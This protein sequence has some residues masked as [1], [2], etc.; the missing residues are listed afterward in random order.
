VQYTITSTEGEEKDE[1]MI[2][3]DDGDMVFYPEEGC[4]MNDIMA[5]DELGGKLKWFS[6]DFICEHLVQHKKYALALNYFPE[7]II[8]SEQYQKEC[9]SSC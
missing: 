5:T 8:N 2:I 6:R 3:P 1:C 9:Q 7:C 4:D